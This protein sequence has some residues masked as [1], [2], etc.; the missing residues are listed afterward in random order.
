ML[1]EAPKDTRCDFCKDRD[2]K[3]RFGEYGMLICGECISLLTDG[4]LS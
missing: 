2:A 4:R 3:Y 1:V